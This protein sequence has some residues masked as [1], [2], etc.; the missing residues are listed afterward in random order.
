M[1]YITILLIAVFWAGSAQAVYHVGSADKCPPSVRYQPSGDVE[2]KDGMGA[3]GWAVAPADLYPP[4]IT[5]DDFDPVTIDLNLPL[6][7]YMNTESDIPL[8][9]AEINAGTIQIFQDGRVTFNG[10]EIS[11]EE[12]Q[13]YLPECWDEYLSQ[14]KQ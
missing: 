5:A 4:A 6:K 1:K 7:S 13:H 14:D 10:K 9:E 3:E 8:E 12:A 2:V 11:H